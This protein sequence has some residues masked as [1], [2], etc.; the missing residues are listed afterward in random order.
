MSGAKRNNWL[1]HPPKERRR[2]TTAKTRKTVLSEEPRCA[3][4]K[5]ATEVDHIVPVCLGGTDDRENLRGIC[6]GCHLTKSSLEA[7]HVRWVVRRRRPRT[8]HS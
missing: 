7:N 6:R 1:T 8:V 3:C 5:P 2:G 4:G